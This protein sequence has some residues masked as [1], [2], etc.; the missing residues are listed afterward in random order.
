[1]I[2]KLSSKIADRLCAEAVIAADDKD[3]YSYGFFVI[4]SRILFFVEATIFGIILHTVVESIVFFVLFS[5]IRSY[6]GGVHASSEFKC[7]AYTTSALLICILS[8]KTLMQY[9]FDYIILILLILSAICILLLSPLD[10]L[11]KPLNKEETKHY[12]KVSWI[13]TGLIIVLTLAF[14]LLDL[15]SI[16]LSCAI[17]LVL[18]SVLL[19]AG[20]VKEKI[21]AAKATD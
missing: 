7:T 9:N 19:I 14:Y 5:I 1:M 17:S 16:S 8:I 21:N 18:E 2:S 11:E 10:S 6:A 3:L 12:R 13:I 20:K 4:L 15:K